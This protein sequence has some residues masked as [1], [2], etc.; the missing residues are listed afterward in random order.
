[1][2]YGEPVHPEAYRR[3]NAALAAMTDHAKLMQALSLS[4]TTR[5]LLRRALREADPAAPDEELHRKYLARL[6]ECHKRTS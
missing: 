1:V 5:A 3:Q 6:R 2:G 4:E